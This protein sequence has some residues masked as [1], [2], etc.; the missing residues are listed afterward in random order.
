MTSPGFRDQLRPESTLGTWQ[1][2]SGSV[3]LAGGMGVSVVTMS[4]PQGGTAMRD[5]DG[6][7]TVQ[8]EDPENRLLTSNRGED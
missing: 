2:C 6:G 1:V 5:G 4:G 7:E 8:R 3:Y